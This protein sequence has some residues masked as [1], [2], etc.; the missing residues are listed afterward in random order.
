MRFELKE[1]CANCPFRSDENR[2]TF[3]GRE[4]A[5]QIEEQA[6]R[7]GFPCH[8]SAKVKEDPLTGEEG[9]VFGEHTQHC[10]GYILLQLRDGGETPWPGIGNDEDLADRLAERLDW[11]APVF[12][13]V[14]QFLQANTDGRE[15]RRNE[16][17]RNPTAGGE[18]Q[19]HAA[20]KRSDHHKNTAPMQVQTMHVGTPFGP[21][22][23][24][25]AVCGA[26][27]RIWID[28]DWKGTDEDPFFV[29]CKKCEKKLGPDGLRQLLALRTRFQALRA[30]ARTIVDSRAHSE[31]QAQRRATHLDDLDATLDTL[32]ARRDELSPADVDKIRSACHDA[33]KRIGY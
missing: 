24:E 21:T 19:A 4:R 28:Q 23:R 10:A 20:S 26:R 2:I 18:H 6:Y 29:R 32:L 8:A 13:T 14:E 11:N 25:A 31:E 5:E 3:N 17:E 30:E 27:G 12:E 9:F 16:Q 7:H 33:L 1:P 15:N 22:I